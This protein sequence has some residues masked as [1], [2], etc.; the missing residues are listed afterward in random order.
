VTMICP[1][2]IEEKSVVPH[3]MYVRIVA[4]NTRLKNVSTLITKLEI[5]Y[6]LLKMIFSANQSPDTVK[7]HEP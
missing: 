1:S 7:N 2:C 4:T 6:S 3:C 5:K